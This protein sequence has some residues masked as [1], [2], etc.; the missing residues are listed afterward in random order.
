MIRIPFNPQKPDINAVRQIVLERL[1]R[2][3]D[4]KALDHTGSGFQS[5]VEYEGYSGPERLAFFALQVFWQLINEGIIAP[6]H[7]PQ[8]S[9]ANLPHFHITEYGKIVLQ[10]GS[11]NP[12][13]PTGY[14]DNIMRRISNPDDTVIAYLREALHSFVKGTPI[15]ST[16]ML[17]IAAERVFLL[18][19]ESLEK[20]LSDATER[21]DFRKILDRYQMKPKLDWVNQK[22]QF[23]QDQRKRFPAFPENATLMII[24]MYNYIRLQRNDLGHPRES[25]PSVR[26]EEAFANLQI[27]PNY[28][29]TAEAV[30]TFLV[31]NNI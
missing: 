13:D 14:L 24:A 21:S 27:F 30:R 26:K 28:Y 2:Q 17:G 20:A 11:T 18:L 15:A 22:F 7:S 6:G 31:S 16:V 23:I 25:P 10:S 4:W 29:E 12:H 19:A 9:S 8:G 5:Y 3:P 1:K